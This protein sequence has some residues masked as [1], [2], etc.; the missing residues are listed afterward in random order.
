M[1]Q[2]LIFD[3]VPLEG[4]ITAEELDPL[5]NLAYRWSNRMFPG[6]VG[7]RPLEPVPD[8]LVETLSWT[9]T[10]RFDPDG[11]PHADRAFDP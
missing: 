1:S 11:V 4:P 10:G 6:A 2:L 5:R 3:S 9:V 8:Q 7:Q